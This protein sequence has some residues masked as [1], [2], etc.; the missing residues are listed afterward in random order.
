MTLEARKYRLIKLITGLDDELLISKLESLLNE[1]SEED[2]ILVNLSKPMR[3][4]LD[5][6]ELIKE[7]NYKHPSKELLNKIIEAAD[8]EESIEDLLAMI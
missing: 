8:I 4:K 6:D 1:L 5:I 7:Q 3:E 2:R